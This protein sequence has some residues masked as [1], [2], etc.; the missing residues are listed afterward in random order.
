MV[1]KLVKDLIEVTRRY[2]GFCFNKR[3]WTVAS[4]IVSWKEGIQYCLDRGTVPVSLDEAVEARSVLK[5]ED[6]AYDYTITCTWGMYEKKEGVL[7]LKIFEA[8]QSVLEQVVERLS[9]TDRYLG[10]KTSDALY[11]TLN[12]LCVKKRTVVVPSEDI[13]KS[14]VDSSYASCNEIKAALPKQAGNNAKIM[15]NFRDS[16]GNKYTKG[17]FWFLRPNLQ[18]GEARVVPLAL[19][20]DYCL[21]ND[22]IAD[23]DFL[24]GRSRGLAPVG[25]R[26]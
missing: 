10:L 16:A 8:T 15:K 21:I 12:K 9:E 24:D 6:H 11:T 13:Q 22:V 5:K 4:D 3:R 19:G 14:V 25:A 20:G 23:D 17:Y 1:V 18:E 7:R 26:K 2:A